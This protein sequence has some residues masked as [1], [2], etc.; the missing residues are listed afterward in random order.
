MR[1]EG[2]FGA[3]TFIASVNSKPEEVVSFGLR[4]DK[5]GPESVLWKTSFMS[6]PFFEFHLPAQRR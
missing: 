6:S 3:T 5:F 1:V 2:R 4:S